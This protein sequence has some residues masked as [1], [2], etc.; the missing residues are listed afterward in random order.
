MDKAL[1]SKTTQAQVDSLSLPSPLLPKKC[2]DQTSGSSSLDL[3]SSLWVLI[4][5]S[6]SLKPS[7]LSFTIPRKARQFPASLP[8]YLFAFSDGSD[9]SCSAPHGVSLTLMSLTATSLCT[10]CSSS[11]SCS[12]LLPDGCSAS[13][14]L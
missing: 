3:P 12:A 4:P 1:L 10:L 7:Q 2:P 14:M 8:P 11:V 13:K 9:H 5:P 6:H